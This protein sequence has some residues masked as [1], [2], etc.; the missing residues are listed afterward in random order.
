MGGADCDV[1]CRESQ[2]TSCRD[3][4]TG[5]RGCDRSATQKRLYQ[6]SIS[7]LQAVCLEMKV[8]QVREEAVSAEDNGTIL[9]AQSGER[10]LVAQ[11]KN[12]RGCRYDGRVDGDLP[13][14]AALPSE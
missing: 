14:L 2:L 1:S 11:G 4:G 5:E 8:A 12:R 6:E 9:L 13:A 3:R 7:R 10:M